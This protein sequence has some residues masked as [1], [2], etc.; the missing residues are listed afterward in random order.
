MNR[1]HDNSISIYEALINVRDGKYV[2]PA[3]Q[4]QFVW[5]MDKIEKLWDSI[6]QG[7]PISTFLFWHIDENNVS[8]DTYFCNFMKEMRFDSAKNS[9]GVNYELR[10]VDTTVSSTAVLDGQ[11]RLTSLFIS[12]MGS[13]GIRPKHH[14]KQ[15]NERN[16]TNLLLEL[17]KNKITDEDEF[18]SKTFGIKFSEKFGKLDPS[19][20]EMRKILDEKFKNKETRDEAIKET[21]KYVPTASIEYATNLLNTL[22]EKI[23]DEKLIRY[24]EIFDMNSDDALEMFIRFN[25]GGVSLKKSDITFSI[26]SAYWPTAK[27][28]FG[29]VLTGKYEGF[30]TDFIIRCALMLY[31]DVVKSNINR[32]VSDQLKDNWEK[33]VKALENTA[34]ILECF[35]VDISKFRSG[36]NVLIPIIFCV[37]YNDNYMSCL[38]GIEKYLYRA[39]F[40]TLFKSGTT[41]KLQMMKTSIMSYNFEITVEMLDQINELRVSEAKIEELTYAEKGSTIAGEVLYYLSKDWLNSN[42]PYEQDHLH[43]HE[44][45]ELSEPVGVPLPE[46][47]KWRNSRDRL[48]N[49]QLLDG[50]LNASKNDMSLQQYYDSK[51]EEQRKEFMEHAFIPEGV[52]LDIG[53]YWEFFEARKQILIQKIKQLIC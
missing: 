34:E 43:P 4:R 2:M 31:G 50:I 45:F 5:N 33:F 44:R 25:S 13:T 48:P 28:H 47:V 8:S 19:Q 46:W 3:F 18:N 37:Y 21:I 16:L 52:S 36:W 38:S 41:S 9:D 15:T 14:R 26:L 42:L 53:K 32:Y 6:L 35:K 12:L 49:L 1:L 51:N 40:F 24:T 39:I 17:N 30:G 11:Q 7:Y 23:Y 20:F 29:R 22:C 27:T 10:P